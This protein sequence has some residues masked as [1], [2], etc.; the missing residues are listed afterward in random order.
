MFFKP[1]LFKA[2]ANAGKIC[3]FLL[4]VGY[5]CNYYF[6]IFSEKLP[7]PYHLTPPPTPTQVLRVEPRAWCVIGKHSTTELTSH[8]TYYLSS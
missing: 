1:V 2:R 8:F 7:H 3:L 6:R 4:R 5:N